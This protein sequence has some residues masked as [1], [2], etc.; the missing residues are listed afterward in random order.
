MSECTVTCISIFSTNLFN[1]Y[2]YW[3][4]LNQKRVGLTRRCSFKSEID[5]D[6]SAVAKCT[7]YQKGIYRTSSELNFRWSQKT[8]AA[9]WGFSFI[10][11][12]TRLTLIKKY[13][14][15]SGWTKCFPSRANILQV[16][17]Q[18]MKSLA[19]FVWDK[20]RTLL[21]KAHLPSLKCCSL[22]VCQLR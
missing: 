8:A 12:F 20:R 5:L 14:I 11:S 10:T 9:R 18:L 22:L 13:I 3:L 16:L 15:S 2:L 7:L 6:W 19:W 17:Q 4:V 1:Q 21:L